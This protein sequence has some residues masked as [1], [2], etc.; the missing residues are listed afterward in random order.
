MC[1]TTKH[2]KA[3]RDALMCQNCG[4][5]MVANYDRM[6]SHRKNGFAYCDKECMYQ[7]RG[8]VFRTSKT[9]REK[10]NATYKYKYGRESW[11]SDVCVL[12]WM[13][14]NQC[15]KQFT[16]RT[17]ETSCSETCRNAYRKALYEQELRQRTMNRIP[18]LQSGY[19][20][21]VM[22]G[23]RSGVQKRLSRRKFCSDKCLVKATKQ[24]R[25]HWIRTNGPCEYIDLDKL[26]KK[27][28]GKCV[29]CGCK[30]AKQTGDYQDH[31]A[32]IDHIVPLAKGG[33]HTWNNVQLMCHRCNSVKSSKVASG[34]QLLLP[35]LD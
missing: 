28:K 12:R 23:N 25:D 24:K 3:S 8:R 20:V 31:G 15:G 9:Y 5:V 30:V 33:W 35:M 19:F 26:M 18:Y 29:E 14:C 17:T 22:C 4:A 10:I 13:K 11:E 34:T 1:E 21:C 7:D 27:H 32:T 6:K 16:R 2:G